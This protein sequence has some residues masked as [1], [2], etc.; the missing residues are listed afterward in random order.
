LISY[1]LFKQGR[2]R[3]HEGGPPRGPIFPV[4]RYLNVV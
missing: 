2:V 3:I 4:C 1:I